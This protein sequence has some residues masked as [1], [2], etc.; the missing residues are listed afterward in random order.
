VSQQWT[1]QLARRGMTMAIAEGSLYVIWFNLIG[2]NFLTGFLLHLG[3]TNSQVGLTAALPP[4]SNLVMLVAAFMLARLP[5]R[6]PLLI[7]GAWIHRPLWTLAGFIPLVLPQGAWVWTYLACYF[8]ANV[9][10]ALSVPPWQSMMADTV[11]ADIRGRFWGF[12]AAFL[13]SV[14]IAVTLAAGRYLDHHPGY[15]GFKALYAVGVL[16][17]LANLCTWWFTPEPPYAPGTHPD[18]FFKHIMVPLRSRTFRWTVAVSASLTLAYGIAA[19]FYTVRMLKDLSLSYGTVS[20]VSSVG[21]VAAVVASYLLGRVLDRVGVHRALGF[22]PPLFLLA[23]VPWFFIKAESLVL[24]YTAIIVLNVLTAAQNLVIFN[25]NFVISPQEGRPVYLAVYSACNGLGGFVAP[26]IGSRI[27]SGA[28]FS[29]LLVV[30]ILAYLAILA[31][32]LGKVRAV[33]LESRAQS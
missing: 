33:V 24:L 27:L 32:W 2:N 22:L 31:L 19:P 23:P 12:R 8:V 28:G 26:L 18:S 6:L 10:V 7:T 20:L 3:A 30:T 9:A 25:L 14:G 29:A 1:P 17:A 15:A 13:Q 11:P 5:R 4:L 21:A 16:F